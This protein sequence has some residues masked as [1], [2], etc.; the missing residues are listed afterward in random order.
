VDD[1]CFERVLKEVATF[2]APESTSDSG[3]YELKDEAFDDVNPFF[4]HYTRNKRE[5]VETILRNRLRKRTGVADPV[6]IPKPF[7]VTSG[8]FSIIPSTFES[9]ALLQVMFYG[10][11]NILVLTYSSGSAP[12]SAEAILDQVL[13]L[14]MLAIVERAMIFSHMS[15]ENV[16]GRKEPHRHHLHSGA[17]R[18]V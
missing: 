7:G 8:P 9:D 6:I 14:I 5:E 11:Y 12:P 1:I 17:S 10:P 2:K 16:R 13:H 15:I 4:Y 3:V 18:Q